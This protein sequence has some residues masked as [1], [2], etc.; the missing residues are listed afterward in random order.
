[1]I[2]QIQKVKGNFHTSEGK[3]PND[4][5]IAELTGLSLAYVRLASQC[6]RSVGSIEQEVMDGWSTKFMVRKR[7]KSKIA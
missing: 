5:E 6:S 2:N 3:Y 1:M 4:E 7:S